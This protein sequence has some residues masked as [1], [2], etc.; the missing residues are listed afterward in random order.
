M[1]AV[2]RLF[3]CTDHC[4]LLSKVIQNIYPRPLVYLSIRDFADSKDFDDAMHVVQD[5]ADI[6][7]D[8]EARKAMARQGLA[9]DCPFGLASCNN[10]VECSH[11]KPNPIDFTNLWDNRL[12]LP[13]VEETAFKPTN[14]LPA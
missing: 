2:G 4:A 10:S 1:G 13:P 3:T 14:I 9:V 7:N 6:L 11:C 5:F 12:E 8:I